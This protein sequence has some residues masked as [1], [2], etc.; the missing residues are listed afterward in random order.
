MRG[1]AGTYFSARDILQALCEAKRR[2]TSETSNFEY[3][4]DTQSLCNPDQKLRF[5]GMD[6]HHHFGIVLFCPGYRIFAMCIDVLGY[7]G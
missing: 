4:L 6:H 2:I 1:V 5:Q 7:W 3:F